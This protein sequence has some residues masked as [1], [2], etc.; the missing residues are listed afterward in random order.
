[1][2]TGT[3]ENPYNN[4]FL[5]LYKGLF[6]KCFHVFSGSHFCH[7]L[8]GLIRMQEY[9][10]FMENI[11]KC[12]GILIVFYTQLALSCIHCVIPES[13]SCLKCRNQ[14]QRKQKEGVELQKK[15]IIRNTERCL[16]D[17]LVKKKCE[18]AYWLLLVASNHTTN[19][20]YVGRFVIMLCSLCN[21]RY[22]N[23]WITNTT[24]NMFLWKTW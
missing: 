3:S 6:R 4:A 2:Y 8:L 18:W 13:I 1:M 14:K 20:L 12:V 22:E 9:E 24:N 15:C 10:I 7:S 16:L 19:L 5:V 11:W 23:K 17:M 21:N